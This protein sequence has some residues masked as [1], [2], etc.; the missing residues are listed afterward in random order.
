[1]LNRRRFV[2]TLAAAGGAQLAATPFAEMRAQTSERSHPRI[3]EVEFI[4]VRGKHETLVGQ[5]HQPQVNPL[6]VYPEYRPAPYHDSKEATKKTEMAERLYLRI[7][8]DAGVDGI[9]GSLDPEIVPIV[10]GDLRGFLLGKDALATEATWD[11]LY[12]RNRHGRY[13]YYMMAVSAVDNALWDLR[14]RFFNVPVFR[15][16]GGPTR[17]EVEAYGSCLGF[18]VEPGF[19]AERCRKVQ[20]MGFHYQKWFFAYGL[21]DGAAGREKNVQLVKTLRE[22][23]G[24]ETELMFDAFSGW[25]LQYAIAWAK[26]AERYHPFWIEEAFRSDQVENFAFL[27][28]ATSVPVATGEHLYGRWEVLRFLQAEALSVV[29][30]D[31]EWCGGTSELVKICALVSA[32]GIR[33]IPHNHNIRAALHVVFSQSPA[34]CPLMECLLNMLP[35]KNY[36]EKD[37]PFPQNG[38]FAMPQRPG[39]G[40]ELDMAK[41]EDM[42]VFNHVD[43]V[44]EG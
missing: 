35:T 12:R 32:F 20:E 44:P 15:L 41:V 3:S 1:M 38:K 26:E 34:T 25:D 23:L 19:V 40:V 4:R 24:E 43:V 7:K 14:G 2:Q 31:P 22:T 30:A 18:S 16:L 36:F 6:D 29:Q 33:A 8:S 9:Y 21:S 27:R 39:F 42:K 17:S 11:Q 5:N 28:R 13:G 10:L 37:P